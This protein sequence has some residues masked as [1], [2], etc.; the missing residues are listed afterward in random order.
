MIIIDLNMAFRSSN[1]IILHLPSFYLFFLLKYI[2][3]IV[4][5]LYL[6]I[7]SKIFIP[8]VVCKKEKQN[9]FNIISKKNFY[10][11][12]IAWIYFY[13]NFILLI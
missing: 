2:K 12:I 11:Y 7:F 8:G 10:I 1:I 5:T 3:L 4:T 9:L 6:F 13:F